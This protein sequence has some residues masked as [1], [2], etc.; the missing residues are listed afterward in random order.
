MENTP[1]KPFD[2]LAM[3]KSIL[4]TEWEKWLRSFQIYVEAEEITSKYR[5]RN[6]LLHLGGTQLQEVAYSLPG[7]IVK[8]DKELD[9]D[10]FTVLV[11]KLTEHFLRKRSTAF[12][13]QLFR[14]MTP[15][16]GESFAQF[17]VRLRQQAKNCYFGSTKSE[18]QEIC[19]IDK[20]VDS[21]ASTKLKR[22]LLEKKVSLTEV[23]DA[24]LEDEDDNKHS[25][26]LSTKANEN[27]CNREWGRCGRLDHT[28]TNIVCPALDTK[29][30]RCSGLDHYA[31]KCRAGRSFGFGRK[32]RRLNDQNSSYILT[33]NTSHS[34]SP[35]WT[36]E[37]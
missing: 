2:Y 18:I 15:S 1:I 28:E 34:F 33:P 21:W 35:P 13:R 11:E 3:D 10:V 31:E 16:K 36:S 17:L 7:A 27:T 9:N 24:C 32:R 26:F 19:L 22:K 23:I 37:Y 20:I 12:E 14:S 4:R 29:C 8:Y 5:Q 6:K 30:N 25:N